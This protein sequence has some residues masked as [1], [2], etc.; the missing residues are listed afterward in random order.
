VLEGKLLGPA[1]TVLSL[2]TEF[3]DNQHVSADLAS[4][5]EQKRKQDCE[6][7]A[8]RRLL[9]GVR[10]EFPQLQLCLSLD[11]LYGCGAGFALGKDFKVSFVIVFKEGS[12]PT[13]WQEFQTLLGLCPDNQLEQSADGWRHEYR[14]VDE[15]HYT[16]TDKR[17]WKLKAI[18]YR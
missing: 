6:L 13:L 9:E 8:S 17:E 16:D 2:A 15:L 3:I 4:A 14:W 1:E 7:K 18:Q 12:I 10:K 11:A 5:G